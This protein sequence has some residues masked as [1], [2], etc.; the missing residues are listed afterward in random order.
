[1]FSPPR[2]AAWS[3]CLL[4]ALASPGLAAAAA[5]VMAG[6]LAITPVTAFAR[7]GPTKDGSAGLVVASFRIRVNNPGKD[8]LRLGLQGA[9]VSAVDSEGTN[10]LPHAEGRENGEII[11]GG[12]LVIHGDAAHGLDAA[13]AAAA[14]LTTLAAGQSLTV[15][16]SSARGVGLPGG[17][18]SYAPSTA[19]LSASLVLIGKDAP[20][21]IGFSLD[22]VPLKVTGFHVGK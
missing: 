15:Q 2:S 3:A 16:I 14:N 11:G 9:S 8:A 7:V 10:L 21:I 19:S 22:D 1:M 5:P 4:I 20:Q 17:T 18:P 6:P 13:K 12:L